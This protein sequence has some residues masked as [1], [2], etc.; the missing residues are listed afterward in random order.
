MKR[1]LR[2]YSVY[3]P[4]HNTP[5]KTHSLNVPHHASIEF[6]LNVINDSRAI[7]MIGG[8]E[9]INLAIKDFTNTQRNLR[10]S[11]APVNKLELNL[12]PKDPFSHPIAATA[13]SN[14]KVLI[15]LSL[16]KEKL[17]ANDGNVFQTIKGLPSNS[18][19]VKPVAIL[20]KNFRFF[21]MGDFQ[22]V[23]K[24][25]PFIE[26]FGSS[27]HSGNYEGIK[28]LLKE[29]PGPLESG[30]NRDLDIPPLPRFSRTSLPHVYNYHSNNATVAQATEDGMKLVRKDT[31]PKL[32]SSI[33]PWNSDQIP[34][35]PPQVLMDQFEKYNREAESLFKENSVRVPMEYEMVQLVTFLE[36]LFDEKPIW[37]RRHIFEIIPKEWRTLLKVAL[38][39]VAY[40]MKRG[41]FRYLYIKFGYSPKADQK[42]WK[43]QG[44][45]FRVAGSIRDLD[46][47]D[48]VIPASLE[49]TEIPRAFIFD[50][51]AIPRIFFFQLG[52]IV[53]PD[54][55]EILRNASILPQCHE[56]F[57]WLDE[58]SCNRVRHVMRYKLK[59]LQNNEPI[60][61]SKVNDIKNKAQFHSF[62]RVDD[63]EESEGGAEDEEEDE[64]SEGEDVMQQDLM[65]RLEQYNPDVYKRLMESGALNNGLSKQEDFGGVYR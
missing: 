64:E 62:S 51:E 27:I 53:D 16:P 22:V 23:T 18:F 61:P 19:Q 26:K 11:N 12:R 2:I 25:S 21:E 43:Y 31:K 42:A 7:E 3:S 41:P 45:S 13:S 33:I 28:N 8:K 54:V 9:K 34:L 15:K 32:H 63:I 29:L 37:I 55:Q 48:K 44:E 6:P 36:K 59:C 49:N 10:A 30:E 17:E 50:G 47:T 39:H 24:K 46:S 40:T 35:G 58:L 38:H 20:D 60:E 52:D 1:I 4:M 57:G 5:A 14:E 56:E 65:V